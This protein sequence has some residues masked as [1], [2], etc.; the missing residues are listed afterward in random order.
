[1]RQTTAPP[2]RLASVLSP[3]AIRWGPRHQMPPG[4][5]TAL[6]ATSG[7]ASSSVRPAP[8]PFNAVA[9]SLSL[10]PNPDKSAPSRDN[11]VSSSFSIS[12]SQPALR[13]IRLSA[14]T[15][16]RRCNS[17]RF[18]RTTTGISIRPS[19]RAAARRPCPAITSPC[20]PTRIG[21]E[22]PNARMLPAISATWEGLW[23]RALRAKGIS[24]SSGQ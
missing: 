18:A 22:N 23:V 1:M 8:A 2:T 10:N 19:C 24:R 12:M 5:D 13:A 21:F 15:S 20:A 7:M 16:C 4:Q 17:D 6:S 9:N 11:S 14:S 3:Q